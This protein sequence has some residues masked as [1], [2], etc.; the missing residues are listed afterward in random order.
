MGPGDL[1]SPERYRLSGFIQYFERIT[2]RML[3]GGIRADVIVPLD[4]HRRPGSIE[5]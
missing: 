5:A 3:D 4:R 1:P 2:R